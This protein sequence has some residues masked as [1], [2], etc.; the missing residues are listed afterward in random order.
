MAHAENRP[1]HH[2]NLKVALIDAAVARA[3]VGGPEGLALRDIATDVGVAP[4]AAYRH[5]RDREHL[6]ALVAQAAREELG[7]AMQTLIEQTK[8]TD[9]PAFD[10]VARLMAC[11]RGYVRFATESPLLFRTAFLQGGGLPDRE[12]DPSAEAELGRCLD[13]LVAVGLLEPEHRRDAATIAWSAVHGLSALLADQALS[14]S[15]AQPANE[16]TEAVLTGVVRAIATTDC[17]WPLGAA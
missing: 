16:A 5:V 4:S 17:H 8:A 15:F 12:D 9:D 2:G 3:R 10:A 14:S 1:Y 13:E 11:G 7:R 6:V